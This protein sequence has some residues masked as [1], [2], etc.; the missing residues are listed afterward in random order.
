MS[1]KP[2]LYLVHRI[3]YPPNKGD[4]LRSYNLLRKLAE[5][6]RVFLGTFIDA[7]ED[8]GAAAGLEDLCEEVCALRIDPRWSR[9]LSL[10][11]LLTGQA[12]SVAYYQRAKLRRWVAG[13]VAQHGIETAVV[14]SGPMAQY[15]DVPGLQ[16]R[17]V[18]F[19]DVDSAKWA[20]YAGAHRWP[21]SWLYRRESA[22]LFA[23]E[24][25]VA[26]QA[27]HSLLT[28]DAEVRLLVQGRPE[29][30]ERVSALRNGVDSS[31]FSPGHSGQDPYPAGGPV[32]VFTGVMDY[33]P[34]VDAVCWFAAEVM[35]LLRESLPG[36]RFCIVGMNPTPQV[37]ALARSPDIIVT[38]RVDD[39]RPWIA[40]ATAAVAPLRVARG[41]QNKVLEAMAMAVPVVVTPAAANGLTASPGAEYLL[42][43]DPEALRAA[44]QSLVVDPSRAAAMGNAGRAHV[45]GHYSWA[46]N[47]AALDRLCAA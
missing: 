15:L 10:K 18:D 38:G 9:L 44:I 29:L 34:N 21:L 28:T 6:H 41:V 2:L 32:L 19:C 4:K 3:P 24:Q 33:W 40:H 26:A 16:R 22:R 43:A 20:E 30:G 14:F 35:P 12:L 39:V 36:V 47:L 8:A 42:A 17:I 25:Q 45:V 37:R 23:F 7:P 1:R 27:D 11:G 46:A 5:Q 31:Y 13:V